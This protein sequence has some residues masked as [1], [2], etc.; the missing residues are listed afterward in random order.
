MDAAVV[1]VVE[2]ELM[3]FE[4]VEGV[5]CSGSGVREGCGVCWG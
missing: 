3:A 2:G 4:A 1:G 5:D